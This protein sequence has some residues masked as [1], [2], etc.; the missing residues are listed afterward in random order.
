MAQDGAILQDDG[1]RQ[2]IV[3][4][5]CHDC[6]GAGATDRVVDEAIGEKGLAFQHQSLGT[7]AAG[8][9]EGAM[10]HF[11]RPI[12]VHLI[13]RVGFDSGVTDERA[14]HK[15]RRTRHH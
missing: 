15:E 10:H 6:A 12:G 9:G 14:V 7:G 13:D 4:L 2:D 3:S 8:A 1:S 5:Q 11:Q